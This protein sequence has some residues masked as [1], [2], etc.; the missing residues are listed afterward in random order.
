MTDTQGHALSVMRAVLTRWGAIC[1]LARGWNGY[2][3]SDTTYRAA[4]GMGGAGKRIPIPNIPAFAVQMSDAVMK[5]P[6]E[7]GNAVTIW[8]AH[9]F[10]AE[11][12]WLEKED[13]ALILGIG[14]KALSYRVAKGRQMLLTRAPHVLDEWQRWEDARIANAIGAWRQEYATA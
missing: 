8:Y 5:L 12:R 3:S 4:F 1:E 13:K 6:D 9:H 7:E 10:N 14:V 2:P 11:G